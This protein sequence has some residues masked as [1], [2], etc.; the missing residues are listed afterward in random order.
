MTMLTDKQLHAL[1][2]LGAVARLQE[3]EAEAA[4]IRKWL[5]GLAKLA[6]DGPEPAAAA[7]KPPRKRKRRSLASRQAARLRMKAYWAAKKR[8]DAPA[9]EGADKAQAS[10]APATA[11]AAKTKT[12]TRPARKPKQSAR[13]KAAKRTKS[14]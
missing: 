7:P 4:A 2:R 12:T 1:A 10:V 9:P 11:S 8:G 14:A 3:L 5:P 6:T 13:P